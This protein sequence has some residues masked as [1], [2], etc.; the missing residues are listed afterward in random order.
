MSETIKSLK[1]DIWK[2]S[3]LE[4]LFDKRF[5]LLIIYRYI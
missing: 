2:N 5:N 3:S 1:S 4:S